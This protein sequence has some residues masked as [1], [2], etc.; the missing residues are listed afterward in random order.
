MKTDLA[1]WIIDALV[2]IGGSAHHVRVA[3]SIW[4]D[5]ENV[6][7]ASGDLIL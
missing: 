7:R 6:L 5:H 1:Q 2:G 4:T 3:E